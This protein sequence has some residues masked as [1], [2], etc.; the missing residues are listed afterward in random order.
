MLPEGHPRNF[1]GV[2]KKRDRERVCPYMTEEEHTFN[3]VLLKEKYI[4]FRQH[5][6]WAHK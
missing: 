1:G 4:N 5:L 6:L 2:E 3:K